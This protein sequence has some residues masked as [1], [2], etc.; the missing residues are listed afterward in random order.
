[1]EDYEKF[2]QHQLSQLRKS[3]E[4]QLT[5]STLFP[6]LGSSTIRF[7]GLPI[8][9]P[10]LS[11]EQK[12]QMQ[13]H[14][15]AKRTCKNT[16][17]D[18]RMSYVQ[19][20]LQS[21]QLRQAPTLEEFFQGESGMTLPKTPNFHDS[22]AR[23][24]QV[25][26]NDV[27]TANLTETVSPLNQTLV[28][29]PHLWSSP[30]LSPTICDAA[31][32]D[33]LP[34]S[35]VCDPLTLSPAIETITWAN[36][37]TETQTRKS[38]S[39]NQQ[40][41]AQ[42]RKSLS[43]N[44]PTETQNRKSLSA[45][46]NR[47]IS[48][49]CFLEEDLMLGTNVDLLADISHRS[50]LSGYVTYENAEV[51]S[52]RTE[53]WES[54]RSGPWGSPMDPG[55]FLCH[56]TWD[57][58][59]TAA[60]TIIS[61]PP[62]NADDLDEWSLECDD[63]IV[64]T[65]PTQ[66][67]SPAL[68]WHSDIT[69]PARSEAAAVLSS[70]P[71]VEDL[72]GSQPREEEQQQ[73]SSLPPNHPEPRIT[74]D[75]QAEASTQDLLEPG[76]NP[77]YNPPSDAELDR[78]SGPYRLS[79]QNLLKKSQLALNLSK[80]GRNQP[81]LKPAPKSPIGDI[82][83]ADP[84]TEI[85][86]GPYRHSLQTLLKKSQEHRRRQRQLKNLTK[87]GATG[88][89]R[90][91]ATATRPHI[92]EEE[93]GFSD[94]ENEEFFH[95]GS[96]VT[97]EGRKTVDQDSRKGPSERGV[98]FPGLHPLEEFPMEAWVRRDGDNNVTKSGIEREAIA[99]E[100]T[101]SEG[102]VTEWKS[103]NG[104]MTLE[105]GQTQSLPGLSV[106]VEL[107]LTPDNPETPPK[108]IA[109]RSHPAPVDE[110][111]A[112]EPFHLVSEKSHVSDPQR[113]FSLG[114]GKF[115]IV[116]SPQFCMSPVR[117]KS[118]VGRGGRG[119]TTQRP[120][121]V[122]NKVDPGNCPSGDRGDSVAVPTAPLAAGGGMTRTNQAEQITKLELNLSSLKMLISDLESTLT[123]T[124]GN[125]LAL[126]NQP[127]DNGDSRYKHTDYQTPS[128]QTSN[129]G[130][131]EEGLRWADELTI[132][133]CEVR[134]PNGVTRSAGEVRKGV[135]GYGSR[136]GRQLRP[137]A[138]HRVTSLTKKTRVDGVFR[139]VPPDTITRRTPTSVASVA[140]NIRSH[141]PISD[142]SG[143]EEPASF[144]SVNESYDVETPSGL[145]LQGGEGSEGSARGY[146]SE[147]KRL[148][149]ENAGGGLG[150]LSKVKRRLVMQKPEGGEEEVRVRP[151]SSTPKA[152]RMSRG[153]ENQRLQLKEAH[154][155]QVR[156]LKEEQ[157]RQQ[158]QLL[159]TLSTRYQQLQSLSSPMP[160]PVS[161]RA[162]P[163]SC[164]G[165]EKTSLFPFSS[166]P[167]SSPHP[168]PHFPENPFDSEPVR[169]LSAQYH[170]L[171]AAAVKGFLTRRLLCT[172]TVGQ[173]RRTIMD[174]RRF[175]QDF[176]TQT[177]SRQD[178]VL[179][180][181]VTLQLRSALY[182]IQDIFFCLP[183]GERMKIISRDRQRI[184]ERDLRRKAGQP[185]LT[186]AKIS[187]SSATLKALERKT[188]TMRTHGKPAE[189]RGGT[190][191]VA[192]V[193]TGNR[194]PPAGSDVRVVRPTRG[195]FRPN[196]QR[197]PKNIPSRRSR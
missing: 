30:H 127:T 197:V 19:S 16:T 193:V 97:A 53:I 136:D 64:P 1:M 142:Q 143:Q 17:S 92:A 56:S 155:A 170:P 135:P 139:K 11:G 47:S 41:E 22:T 75:P 85:P 21:V 145:W 45:N 133:P 2:I 162:T 182:E 100:K 42:T 40:T 131:R 174:T 58:T 57:T 112:Q 96:V 125:Q 59:A 15:T 25:L 99:V 28:C 101:F 175:L 113:P 120:L 114:V 148:T 98:E 3:K 38:L 190:G 187:L 141:R 34:D 82:D 104:P 102:I 153:Q 186:G 116:P 191:V 128:G 12:A 140:S 5:E 163:S 154:A 121:N 74:Q 161:S 192:G 9:P 95:S 8:L 7:H 117:C 49:G 147:G 93:H 109:K 71:P 118:K 134:L 77:H 43:A 23:H 157:R 78:P 184:R 169:C 119:E 54:V 159:Q 138:S 14:K 27:A 66:E 88:P 61:H 149:P 10:L 164:L 150:G 76:Q 63:V 26:Q 137:P 18:P 183:P 129:R 37:P 123:E 51:A 24:V 171:V 107:H 36:Q 32:M 168:G 144:L 180:E 188:G 67:A 80:P 70:P 108:L 194:G 20:I 196:P 48:P 126:N 68:T 90:I 73:S 130:D 69:S 181:R 65:Q 81:E 35:L 55:A 52:S 62:I 91:G 177:S 179:Q 89:V 172:E 94:K 72:T 158:Q 79:L 31:L 60:C 146:Y 132:A 167:P 189:K 151:Q 33:I 6:R 39:A 83:P 105:G 160:L 103:V 166:L 165:D 4:E 124:Q 111:P 86:T 173:L 152:V 178:L 110:S 106:G 46:Q 13:Q 185:L 44:Q 122:N 84:E 195:S 115:K 29:G 50:V 156:A 176:Q 87:S